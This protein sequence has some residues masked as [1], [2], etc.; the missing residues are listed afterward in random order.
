[1]KNVIISQVEL[2]DKQNLS[3]AVSTRFS[4]FNVMMLFDLSWPFRNVLFYPTSTNTLCRRRPCTIVTRW[5]QSA[6]SELG[7]PEST[8]Y[9]IF[10]TDV[11]CRREKISNVVKLVGRSETH[12]MSRVCRWGQPRIIFVNSS[13]TVPPLHR[14]YLGAEI[15]EKQNYGT[16]VEIMW[17]T[18]RVQL[19]AIRDRHWWTAPYRHQTKTYPIRKV[20]N[21][22][23]ADATA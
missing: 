16:S 20:I 22:W 2:A 4:A 1:M 15:F 14:T 3:A 21:H 23:V 19:V 12:A 7:T 8:T 18:L 9:F 5:L 11:R 17:I 10:D 13:Y 6:R